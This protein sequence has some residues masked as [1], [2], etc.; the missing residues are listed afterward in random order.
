MGGGRRGERA[1]EEGRGG[2]ERGGRERE[3]ERERGSQTHPA[4][5]VRIFGPLRDE[6]FGRVAVD[7]VAHIRLGADEHS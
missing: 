5:I 7:G 3:R 1:M 4:I 2:R 6:L